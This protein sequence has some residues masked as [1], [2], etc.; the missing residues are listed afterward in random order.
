MN[1]IVFFLFLIIGFPLLELYV[2]I[3]VGSDIGAL[4]TIILTVLT[5]VIGIALVRIQGIST[6]MRAKE[7][8]ER[9]ETPAIEVLEGT[10]LSAAGFLLLFPGFISDA[11]GFILLIP[12]VRHAIVRSWVAKMSVS[13]HASSAQGE[14]QKTTHVIEGEFR[15]DDD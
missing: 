3:E 9:G 5:A 7:V 6:A 1:P 13:V 15:R 11:A 10:L 2:L 8:M 14:Q 4:P 12:P